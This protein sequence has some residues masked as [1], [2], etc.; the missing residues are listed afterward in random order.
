M[1]TELCGSDLELHGF[2]TCAWCNKLMHQ[3]SALVAV[4]YTQH[5]QEHEWF[6]GEPCKQ[7]WYID[8]LNRAGM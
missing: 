5:Q 1:P 8:R 4:Y 6:C 7:T 3:T 2:T